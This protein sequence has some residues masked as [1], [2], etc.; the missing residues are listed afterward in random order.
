MILPFCAS[1]T[2]DLLGPI[3]SSVR[4]C[5]AVVGVLASVGLFA[6]DLMRSAEEL[7][8]D[9]FDT[10]LAGAAPAHPWVVEGNLGNDRVSLALS[11]EAESPFVGNRV[12]G[13]GVIVR[14]DR[15]AA[16]ARVGLS[17]R[18]T[19]P[20]DGELYLGFD[21]RYDAPEHTS[22]LDLTCRLA[23]RDGN[24]VLL[25]LGAGGRLK[26]AHMGG[27]VR[28]LAPLASGTWYHLA[29]TVRADSA[30]ITL[31]DI[32][33]VRVSIYKVEPK[34]GKLPQT[35]KVA[36][37]ELPQAIT[38]LQFIS[39]APD[40]ATGSWMLD[41]V[42]MAGTVDA[43]R[44]ACWPFEQ[45]PTRKLRRSSKKVFGYYYPIYTNAYSD[46]D[47]GLAWYTRTVLTPMSVIGRKKDRVAAGS[48]LLYRPLPRPPMPSGLSKEEVRLRAMAEEVRLAQQQGMDGLLVDFWADPHPTNGQRFF[49]L[50]SF[51]LLDAARR[52]DPE[53]K[54]LPAV[55][56]SKHL[57]PEAYADSEYV[58]RIAAHPA[59]LRLP[60]GRLVWSMWRTESQ[61]V[62]WW[63]KVMARMEANGTPIAL[64]GQFNSWDKLKDFSQICYGM[65]HWGRRIPG[66]KF[67]WVKTTRPLTE[68]VGFPIC[69][70]DVRT[71]GRWAQD[72]RNSETLRWLWTQAIEDDADW[73]FIY[74]VTDYSEQAMAPSTRIG[75]VPYDLNAYYIQWFKTGKQPE[76][77]RDRL[78]Y[79]HRP[80]HSGVE[81]LKGKPWNYG[82]TG[83]SDQIELL[84]FLAEPGTLKI[85]IGDK[86]FE[87]EAT[88]GITSFKVP[89]PKD[90]AFVPEFSL[91]REGRVIASGKSQYPVMDTVEYPNPMYCAG[92]IAPEQERRRSFWRFLPWVE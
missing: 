9:Q 88:A 26:L 49:G 3:W 20:P 73:A 10:C 41:N 59:A 42:C 28:D 23:D 62:D 38:Q 71:R 67:P 89:L 39:S 66:T 7:P 29:M 87:K 43:P 12:T 2:Q 68:K 79:I 64:V 82:R 84:A 30:T 4:V 15:T 46:Q 58:K 17:R 22:G 24:G 31:T 36:P 54:I 27:K 91:E 19:P 65:V 44:A 74:T 76:I 63:R 83:P 50:S 92:M 13:K 33:D 37:L 25:H 45:K 40:E 70:Q 78:Y 47:P 86:T 52:I 34:G 48:E 14:D 1:R 6:A 51:A 90:V 21:F 57:T 53:F 32:R 18:F 85:K 69:M 35:F 55:Y 16:G 77:V 5:I 60:G 61:S 11:P 8:L 72:S 80:H 75:F 81:Q 56:T